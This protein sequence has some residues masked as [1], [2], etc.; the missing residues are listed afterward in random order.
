[1]VGGA[2]RLDRLDRC[3]DRDDNGPMIVDDVE[4]LSRLNVLITLS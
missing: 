3:R 2:S 1:M 4:A